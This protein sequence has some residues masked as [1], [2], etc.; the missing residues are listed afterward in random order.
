MGEKGPILW[1]V[2]APSVLPGGSLWWGWKAKLALAPRGQPGLVLL[3]LSPQEL[4][5]AKQEFRSTAN[6]PVEPH[7]PGMADSERLKVSHL[8]SA[9]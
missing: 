4:P 6:C 3:L 9:T 2:E 5:G 1:G 8:G 7:S